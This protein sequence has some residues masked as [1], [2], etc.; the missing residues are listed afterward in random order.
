MPSPTTTYLAR[1]RLLTDHTAPVPPSGHLHQHQ[2]QYGKAD[3]SWSGREGLVESASGRP[4]R[5]SMVCHPPYNILPANS[6]YPEKPSAASHEN[7]AR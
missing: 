3:A 7:S 1:W 5:Q 4:G 2:R 6:T